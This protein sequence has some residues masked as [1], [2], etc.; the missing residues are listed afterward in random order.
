[1]RQRTVLHRS[2]KRVSGGAS[3]A[4]DPLEDR[5]DMFG[6]IA[7]VKLFVDAVFAQGGDNVSIAEKLWPSAPLPWTICPESIKANHLPHSS[8]LRSIG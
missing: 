3:G 5:V 1:M 2:F 8:H 4:K 7:H 6:V